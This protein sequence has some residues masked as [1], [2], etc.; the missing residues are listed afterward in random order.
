MEQ[1]D[2]FS[3]GYAMHGVLNES[4]ALLASGF[5]KPEGE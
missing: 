2:G 5:D 3:F 4:W 1:R